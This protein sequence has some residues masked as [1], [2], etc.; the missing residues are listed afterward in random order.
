M[1]RRRE[2]S[3]NWLSGNSFIIEGCWFK[4]RQGQSESKLQLLY[5]WR[6]TVNQFVLATTP[7]TPTTRI[8]VFQLNTYVTSS[9]TREGVCRLQLLL[10]SPAQSFSGLNPAGL[11][12]T[13][14]C[15]RFETPPTWRD[16]SPYFYPPGTG[17]PNYTPRHWVPFSSPPTTRRATVE[18]FDRET[19]Y[20]NVYTVLLSLSGQISE[21]NLSSQIF[22]SK[23]FVTHERY[24][25]FDAT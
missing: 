20:T 13:W 10:V 7:L 24:P 16:R 22:P 9:L 25:P 12:T 23:T 1:K 17:W 21:N 14:Y 18:I 5:D 3:D 15:L 8:S 11:M 6:F 19:S 4:S 2:A